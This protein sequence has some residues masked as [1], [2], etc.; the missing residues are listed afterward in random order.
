MPKSIEVYG[1]DRSLGL[2]RGHWPLRAVCY[3]QRVEDEPSKANQPP[4][5][6]AWLGYPMRTGRSLAV[7]R[8][9]ADQGCFCGCSD[10]TASGRDPG[11][12]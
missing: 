1:A 8:Y 4:S 12:T 3:G 11:R 9:T 7:D 10:E 6:G 5:H 2:G